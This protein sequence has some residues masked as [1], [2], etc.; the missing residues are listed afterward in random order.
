MKQELTCPACG[1]A[2]I[3]GNICPNCET[4]L[5]ALRVLAELPLANRSRDL[6][7]MP[8]TVVLLAPVTILILA[9]TSILN[10]GKLLR[11]LMGK[12]KSDI[13]EKT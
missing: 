3:E 10:S 9:A 6:K 8:A 4:D 7:E 11:N 13:E 1:R 12:S 5:T 2:G